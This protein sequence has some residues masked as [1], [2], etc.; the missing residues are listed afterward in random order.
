[1]IKSLAPF[2]INDKTSAEYKSVEELQ[3]VLKDAPKNNIKNIGLT[4]PYGSGKSSVLRT[5]INTS[6]DY[7]FLTISLATLDTY[8]DESSRKIENGQKKEDLHKKI[9][10][11]ILQQILYKEKPENTPNSSFKKK[12]HLSPKRIKILSINVLIFLLCILVVFE[13][14]FL[15]VETIAKHLNFGKY[16][17]YAD[18]IC[19][20]YLLWGIYYVLTKIFKYSQNFKINKLNFEKTELTISENISIFNRYLDEILYFFQATKYNVVVFE[21]LDRFNDPDIFLKLREINNIIN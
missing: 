15:R 16:N 8:S 11:S 9:E 3:N 14:Q 17:I 12:Y 19:S 13:P 7:C 10:Y 21:D 1:M 2:L 6:K 4:G 18:I 5:L 20:C